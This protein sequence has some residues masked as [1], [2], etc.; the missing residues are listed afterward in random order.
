MQPVISIQNMSKSFDMQPILKDLS[1]EI[2]AG[3][4]VGLLGKNGAGKSTLLE[5]V[6]QLRSSSHDSLKIWGKS[7][8]DL[9]QLEREKIA[10]VAQDTKGFEWMQVDSYLKYLGSFF[11]GF[12]LA[13][14]QSLQKRWNL[15]T[16]KIIGDLSG[17]QKQI[18]RIIQALSVKP[19]LLIL[20]EPV[21]H[22]DP[23]MRRQF[24]GELVEQAYELNSTVIFSTH[25]V[26]DLERVAN[27]VALLI[28]GKI[29]FY[30]T[31][32]ELK[33]NIAHL[34][35]SQSAPVDFA[36]I[37]A[38]LSNCRV[39]EFGAT[40]T[41]I[42]PGLGLDQIQQQFSEAKIDSIPLSLEDWYLEV[43]HADQ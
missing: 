34:K 10:F 28:D 30:Y 1:W 20:D 37:K 6:M 23:T 16:S 19:E 8:K 26:S 22:L 29:D 42:R 13:Y 25:I 32:D 38:F 39:H 41:V 43:N 11:S 12:D 2:Q 9:S 24:L 40:A 31:I 18:L 36:S 27:K 4:I 17:G 5:S 14:C 15:E 35:I 21:A 7:W 3:D 33:E